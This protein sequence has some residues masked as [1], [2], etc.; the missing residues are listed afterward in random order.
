VWCVRVCGGPVEG[1]RGG[2]GGREEHDYL[3]GHKTG[4]KIIRPIGKFSDRSEDLKTGRI[5]FRPVG[6]FS[7]RSEVKFH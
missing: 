4:R 1:G 5:I 6:L 7:D 3:T 2:R